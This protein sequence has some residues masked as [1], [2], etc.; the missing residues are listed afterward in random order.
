MQKTLGSQ[1]GLPPL[2]LRPDSPLK[3]PRAEP[4]RRFGANSGQGASASLREGATSREPRA[5]RGRGTRAGQRGR[6]EL[7]GREAPLGEFWPAPAAARSPARPPEPR[8][9]RTEGGTA[10]RAQDAR[11]GADRGGRGPPLGPRG[12]GAA[13]AER[14]PRGGDA[15]GAVG[16]HRRERGGSGAG[17]PRA[18]LFGGRRRRAAPP[19]CPPCRREPLV[20]VRREWGR[21][22]AGGNGA[23][24]Q[25]QAGGQGRYP[26]RRE[27]RAWAG[28]AG[29]WDRG[30]GVSDRRGQLG[31]RPSG[32]WSRWERGPGEGWA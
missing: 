9:G 11:S 3:S 12:A 23:A 15:S 32:R 28:A 16:A 8:A 20:P 27:P 19:L 30:L 18:P 4:H 21:G 26:G 29:R 7:L 24:G 10:R 1:R 22:A 6:T 5:A 2:T 13:A 17:R 25:G 14:D 31:W